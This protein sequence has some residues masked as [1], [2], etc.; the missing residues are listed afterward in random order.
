MSNN[1]LKP[2]NPTKI[3]VADIGVS[4]AKDVSKDGMTFGK[5]VY[6][7]YKD[8][9]LILQTDKMNLK[10]G[11]TAWDS[12]NGPKKY[13]LN[14]YFKDWSPEKKAANQ[15]LYKFFVDL[16][17]HIKT[18]IVKHSMEWFGVKKP[19]TREFVDTM[20]PLY[21][22]VKRN[23]NKESGEE[24]PPCISLKFPRYPNKQSGKSEFTTRVFLKKN[25]EIEIDAETPNNTI[26]PNSEGSSVI[27]CSLFISKA[28]KKVSLTMN[29]NMIKVYPNVRPVIEYPFPD[30]DTEEEDEVSEVESVASEASEASEVEAE[31][32]NESEPESE[33][34]PESDAESEEEAPVVVE[35][36]PAKKKRASKKVK[37]PTA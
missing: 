37:L 15:E 1:Q 21:P 29:A 8:A 16:E 14:C 28:N 4:K 34:E 32:E 6:L 33:A 26:P 23:S 2:L 17:E 7:N 31:S 12:D 25:K 36:V 27:F 3:N 18:L 5:R 24:Y 19:W 13:T 22:V 20:D 11:L 9:P 35:P 30:S 10:F